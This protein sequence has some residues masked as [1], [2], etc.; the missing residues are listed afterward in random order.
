M[1]FIP[2]PRVSGGFI[3][4]SSSSTRLSHKFLP[5]LLLTKVGKLLFLGK[6]TL[7]GG[8]FFFNLG[9]VRGWC[10]DLDSLPRLAVT[11]SI[12]FFAIKGIMIE[13]LLR[14]IGKAHAHFFSSQFRLIALY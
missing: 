6:A 14:S 9:G 3:N 1:G 4:C 2:T 7:T 13:L 8:M 10:S 12:N 11:A 5:L